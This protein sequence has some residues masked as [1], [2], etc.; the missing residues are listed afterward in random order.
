MTL[1]S[2]HGQSRSLDDTNR[3][4]NMKAFSDTR[5]GDYGSVVKSCEYLKQISGKA[6]KRCVSQEEQSV[7][8]QQLE[9]EYVPK[10]W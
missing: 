4:K 5:I 6:F 8:D 1:F 2:A 10:R 7:F 9:E 3:T